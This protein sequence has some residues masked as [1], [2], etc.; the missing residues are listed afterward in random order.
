MLTFIV[1]T[2]I[3][4]PADKVWDLLGTQFADIATWSNTVQSSKALAG[5]ELP[6]TTYVPAESAPV[7]ARQSTVSN[8]G[9]TKTLVEVLTA[10]SD[11]EQKL[12]F[13]GLGLPSFI[14]YASDEQSVVT[15]SENESEAVFHLEMRVKG[16][17]KL[18][19]GKL[20]KRFAENLERIQAEL[21]TAAESNQTITYQR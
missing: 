9:K 4:A 20:K 7:P 10:Y 2:K 21:K 19:K 8:K 1:K 3:N 15:L 17:F 14:A 18:M 13:Y 16:I 12:K 6:E 5:D 11:E